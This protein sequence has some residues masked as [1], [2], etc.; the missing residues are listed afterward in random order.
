MILDDIL[1]VWEIGN[2][3][4]V[5]DRKFFVWGW[6]LPSALLGLG[7]CRSG[8]AHGG[9]TEESFDHRGSRDVKVGNHE[10]E[11]EDLDVFFWTEAVNGGRCGIV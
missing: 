11:V 8:L 2:N 9:D 6:E 4:Q 5:D 7:R 3:D 1:F 10:E